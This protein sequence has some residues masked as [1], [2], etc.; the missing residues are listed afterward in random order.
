MVAVL[1]VGSDAC[2]FWI[3]DSSQQPSG[4]DS[5][6]CQLGSWSASRSSYNRWMCVV[7]VNWDLGVRVEVAIIDGC[8]W[9]LIT[10][11]QAM[12]NVARFA[13]WHVSSL[14]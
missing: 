7:A 9:W 13:A 5:Q 2:V 4:S 12:A 3:S 8:V 6:W 14:L 11:E 10:R 1:N